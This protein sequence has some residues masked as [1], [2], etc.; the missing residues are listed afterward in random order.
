M[1]FAFRIT[2]SNLLS[3]HR[4]HTGS[5]TTLIEQV[6]SSFSR[7]SCLINYRSCMIRLLLNFSLYYWFSRTLQDKNDQ[8]K[9][10]N[11]F[12]LYLL[13]T[14]EVAFFPIL[15]I[16][17]IQNTVAG[18]VTFYGYFQSVYFIKGRKY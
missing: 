12:L 7:R 4:T 13:S 17:H 18:I 11:R 9:S 16:Y 10:L 14:W 6:R 1:L 2:G 8:Q 5:F 3:A 15:Y